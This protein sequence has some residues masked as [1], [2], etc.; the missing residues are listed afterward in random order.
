VVVAVRRIAERFRESN[1]KVVTDLGARHR[2]VMLFCFRKNADFE[3]LAAIGSAIGAPFLLEI[4]R[5]GPV[6]VCMLGERDAPAARRE[7]A[8]RPPA[9]RDTRVI[10]AMHGGERV[11]C[12]R[13]KYAICVP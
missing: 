1:R 7:L 9:A 10:S 6:R 2:N 13:A 5:G 11:K 4:R 12:F 8:A 3:D